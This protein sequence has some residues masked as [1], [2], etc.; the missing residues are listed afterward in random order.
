MLKSQAFLQIIILILQDTRSSMAMSIITTTTANTEPQTFLT[1]APRRVSNDR[2]NRVV[3]NDL[4]RNCQDSSS[5]SSRKRRRRR[6]KKVSFAS[7][8]L[9][10]VDEIVAPQQ[11]LWYTADE[12]DDI[13]QGAKKMCLEQRQMELVLNEAYTVVS[14]PQ[15]QVQ[16]EPKSGPHLIIDT[17]STKQQLLDVPHFHKQRGLERWSSKQQAI[18]RFLT[19]LHVKTEVYCAEP[20]RMGEACQ[21]ASQP[22]MQLARLMGELDEIAARQE[23]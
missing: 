17:E 13:K 12:L 11:P 9:L 6:K 10:I 1:V 2:L 4:K 21:Q 20:E 3:S 8:A 15:V 16:I 18:S 5:S 19:M 22:A 7:H 23:D 14:Q